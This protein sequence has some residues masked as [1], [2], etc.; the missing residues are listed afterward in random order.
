[1]KKMQ[2]EN[3]RLYDPQEELK[4]RSGH[5]ASFLYILG[6]ETYQFENI[7]IDDAINLIRNTY[8]YKHDISTNIAS[9]EYVKK[10][11]IVLSRGIRRAWFDVQFSGH[12]ANTH[13]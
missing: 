4:T 6:Y 1:M 8:I 13:E 9:Q 7:T 2:S 10:Q 12:E 5:L 3:P 11:S